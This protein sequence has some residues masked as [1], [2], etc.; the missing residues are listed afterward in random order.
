MSKSSTVTVR[1]KPVEEVADWHTEHLRDLEQ[2]AGRNTVDAP[3][4]FVRLLIGDAD[5]ISQ[6]LLGQTKHDPPLTNAGV[7]EPGLCLFSRCDF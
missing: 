2:T 4:V 3:L 7:G 5:Q 6:L 1:E